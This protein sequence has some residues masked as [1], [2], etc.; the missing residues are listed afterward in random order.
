MDI[1]HIDYELPEDLIAQTPIEPRDSARLLVDSP[2]GIQHRRVSDIVEYLQ[3]GD[4]VVVNHT[5]VLPARLKLKRRT[6]GAVEVLLLE[7][8]DAEQ[9][10]WE[11]LVRPGG[12]LSVGEELLDGVG[13]VLLRIGERSAAGDTFYVHFAADS[14]D[15]VKR[16]ILE[17][18]EI[19]LPPYITTALADQNRFHARVARTYSR[20]GC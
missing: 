9:M 8:L 14:H 19:P 13:A 12:K 10:Q 4:V 20:S 1:S 15:E 5:R 7:E 2:N 3:P 6:G 16:R 17:V 18:G 11:A